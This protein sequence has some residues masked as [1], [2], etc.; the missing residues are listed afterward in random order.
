MKRLAMLFSVAMLLGSCSTDQSS[1]QPPLDLIP[2]DSFA[3]LVGEMQIVYVINRQTSRLEQLDSLKSQVYSEQACAT[4]NVS[5]DRYERSYAY[6]LEQ[7]D[8]ME[9]VF[10]KA[11]IYLEQKDTEVK[12]SDSAGG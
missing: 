1:I 10:E 11:L 5:T 2:T 4:F 7:M 12:I 3:Y 6:Y 8:T 9:V